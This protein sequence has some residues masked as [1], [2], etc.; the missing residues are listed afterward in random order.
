MQRH[1]SN[2]QDQFGNAVSGVSVRVIDRVTAANATI[3]SDDGV[4]T[5]TN[6]FT[7]DADGE[8]FFYA[9]NGRYD[10][11]LS[12]PVSETRLDVIFWDPA[13]AG[14]VIGSQRVIGPDTIQ[15]A[16]GRM[17]FCD[18]GA[19]A[20]TLTLPA[21]PAIEDAAVAVVHSD[22]NIVTNNI[23]IAR[24]GRN[25]MGLAQDMTVNTTNAAFQLKWSGD[26]TEG[27]RLVVSNV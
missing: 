9:R 4:T 27:W 10:I 14:V 7:N 8:F 13:D 6:P 21:T 5:K 12:G 1:S 22:G 23:T 2:V 20:I 19:G 24:N 17:Y 16:F 11:E 15:T 25:I 18:V 3:Y 26:L